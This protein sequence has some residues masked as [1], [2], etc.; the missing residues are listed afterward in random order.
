MIFDRAFV[1]EL[2]TVNG[3]A[4]IAI[5]AIVL[6]TRLIRLLGQAAEGQIPIDA[7]AAFLGLFLLGTLPML[8]SLTLFVSV[9]LA[10]TRSWRDS[11]MIVW[12]SS[13]VPLVSWLRPLLT[14]AIPQIAVIAVLTIVIAPWLE[15]MEDR[16]RSSLEARDDITTVSAGVFG[17]TGSK[18]RVFFVEAVGRSGAAEN[19]FVGSA[20]PELADI[21]VGRSG[22]TETAPN[23][24]RFIVLQ[25]GAHYER[26]PGDQAYRVTEFERYETRV[27]TKE[28]AAPVLGAKT[29]TTW[30]LIKEGGRSSL[31]ELLWRF[32]VPV[33]ALML[34]LIAIPLS[35]VDPRARR[36][37]N[38]VLALLFYI[39]YLNLLSIANT[40]VAQ[41]QLGFKTG[42]LLAHGTMVMLALVLFIRRAHL[43]WL[44]RTAVSLSSKGRSGRSK[45]G[46]FPFREDSC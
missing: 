33:C 27:Q 39:V 32:G 6:T 8:L 28:L 40:R 42:F 7:V 31:G 17:E 24:D 43:T 26:L 15:K 37:G 23:G 1:R 19:V 41:G 34:V 3:A 12:L 18:D 35:I 11:E 14:F 29:Q 22:H 16:F 4:F 10:L 38:L 13:G 30:A 46:V 5:A 45:P 44:R 2:A 36:S 20:K 21:T 9:L 25:Q